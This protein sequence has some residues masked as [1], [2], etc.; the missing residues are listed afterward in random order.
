MPYRKR[1]A[2]VVLLA[3]AYWALLFTLTH[4]KLSPPGPADGW[5]KA[6][7]WAAYALLAFLLSAAAS[8]F[9]RFGFGLAACLIAV[10]AV[11]GAIDELTQGFTESRSPD[12]W[13]WVADLTGAATG[14]A[15]FVL[16]R[17]IYFKSAPAKTG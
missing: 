4:I 3:A 1:A 2:V 6:A 12:A 16:A 5:D 11:Y 7:H 8:N 14:V 17:R 15:A 10:I 9:W 13:D